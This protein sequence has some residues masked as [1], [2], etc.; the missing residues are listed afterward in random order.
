VPL[1]RIF[2]LNT[3]KGFSSNPE[4]FLLTLDLPWVRTNYSFVAHMFT[5]RH[6][7]ADIV[8][9]DKRKGEHC[10]VV[11]RFSAQRGKTAHKMID[12]YHAAAG[13]KRIF[14]Y[15]LGDAQ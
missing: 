11:C 14:G 3:R 13:E 5:S 1:P 2:C 8:P 15:P 10:L 4:F 6:H 7:V 9:A 12:T